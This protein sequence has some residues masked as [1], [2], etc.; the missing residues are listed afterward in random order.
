MCFVMGAIVMRSGTPSQWGKAY[1]SLRRQKQHPYTSLQ[2]DYGDS[3]QVCHPT[4]SA[5]SWYAADPVTTSHRWILDMLPK[6]K[7]LKPLV[8]E[9]RDYIYFLNAVN[10]DPEGSTLFQSQPKGARIVQRRFQWGDRD[11]TGR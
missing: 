2:E 8:S 10:C 4:G 9:F 6:G 1:S 3:A 5:K 7:K 11:S